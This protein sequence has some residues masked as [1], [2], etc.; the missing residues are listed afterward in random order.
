M[1]RITA[2]I[3]LADSPPTVRMSAVVISQ[4]PLEIFAGGPASAPP[5]E[6][7]DGLI[8]P[9]RMSSE[10]GSFLLLYSQQ[11]ISIGARGHKEERERGWPG[12]QTI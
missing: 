8:T 1:N 6:E 7:L 12:L 10:G 11:H 4:L 9:E 2:G 5:D 3:T